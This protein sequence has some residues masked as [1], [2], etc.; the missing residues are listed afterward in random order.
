VSRNFLRA[1][2]RQDR[3]RRHRRPGRQE[4]RRRRPAL[5]RPAMSTRRWPR[6][7]DRKWLRFAM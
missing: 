1:V 3:L 2:R 7:A 5:H 4:T 6:H